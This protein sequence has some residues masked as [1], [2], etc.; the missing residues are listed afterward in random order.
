MRV[1]QLTIKFA[2]RKECFHVPSIRREF[3]EG[4]R[5]WRLWSVVVEMVEHGRKFRNS[6]RLFYAHSDIW[7]HSVESNPIHPSPHFLKAVLSK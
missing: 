7:F 1:S 5:Y 3:L 6:G 2:G 4:R